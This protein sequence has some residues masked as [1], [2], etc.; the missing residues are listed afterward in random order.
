MA[1]ITM[2]GSLV[3]RRHGVIWYRLQVPEKLRPL[4]GWEI[5]KTLKTS[6]WEEARA[7]APAVAMWAQRKLAEAREKL[8]GQQQAQWNEWD[9]EALWDDYEESLNPEWRE[10]EY[11]LRHDGIDLGP[12]PEEKWRQPFSRTP[13]A[14]RLGISRVLEVEAAIEKVTAGGPAAQQAGPAVTLSG[15]LQ[16]WSTERKP[17]DVGRMDP[18]HHPP[19]QPRGP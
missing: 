12:E 19:D 16:A 13:L 6:D 8:E 2:I 10:W 4:L 5:T 15:L 9:L 17:P 11:A 3:R 7:R 14:R 18:V 1:R